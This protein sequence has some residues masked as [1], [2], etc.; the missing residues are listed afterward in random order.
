V[1][2]YSCFSPQPF[3]CPSNWPRRFHPPPL[4]S[5]TQ[6]EQATQGLLYH[7]V[8]QDVLSAEQL[9]RMSVAAWPHIGDVSAR[10]LESGRWRGQPGLAWPWPGATQLSVEQLVRMPQAKRHC[11][12][13][14][15]ALVAKA[16]PRGA[17]AI[18]VSAAPRQ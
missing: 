10:G 2:A 11:F 13:D 9:A 5:R 17:A 15:R 4:H 14:A 7:F 1:L 8:F 6:K 12:G 16:R 18:G 3:A